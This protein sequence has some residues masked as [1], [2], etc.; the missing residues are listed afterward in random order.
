MIVEP[1]VK[2]TIA[3]FDGQNL[4]HAVREA[5]GYHYPNYDVV[6]LAKAICEAS[7]WSLTQT[8]FYTGVPDTA[9]D[10][11]WHDFWSAKLLAMSR[12]S[13]HI[14]SRA[15]RYRNRTMKLPDGKDFTFM[16]GE[17]KGV[18][19]RIAV[20]IIRLA[21]SREY[22]VALVFSQDQDLSEVADEIRVI[23]REQDRWMK[24]AC[25]F[26]FSP[27]SENRRGIDKTDWIRIARATYDACVDAHD[28][29]RKTDAGQTNPDPPK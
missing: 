5:F 4:Y 22:D 9:D 18:D 8:R 24:V 3:F 25:A 29:R 13:V 2:R 7:D 23:A 27:T 16:V 28:Y 6:A 14:F 11:Y 10:K 21:H 1:D 17:E 12:Q 19:V 15:L 26:P 20:D